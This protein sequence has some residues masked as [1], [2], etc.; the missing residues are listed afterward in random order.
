MYVGNTVKKGPM[1]S[2]D[3]PL[4]A[5]TFFKTLFVDCLPIWM[6]LFSLM[7]LRKFIATFGL[8]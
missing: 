7:L 1:D 3:V 2:L 4:I 6:T 8:A 5:I